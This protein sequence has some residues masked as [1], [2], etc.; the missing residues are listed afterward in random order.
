MA[1]KKGNLDKLGLLH[2]IPFS[3]KDTIGMKG[4]LNTVGCALHCFKE[5]DQ[6]AITVQRFR[7]EG[8]IPLVRGNVPQT[9][10][11]LHTTNEIWGE[12]LNPID[13]TRTAGGSSGGDSGLIAARC[14]PICLGGDIAGSL[15]WPAIF[16]GIYG[17]KPSFKRV[18]LVG[19]SPP[20][21]HRISHFTHL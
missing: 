5:C 18:S 20:R 1:R 21:L 10:F 7:E 19:L 3:V 4:F 6:D 8:G 14:V 9:C 15:R 17:F 12:S 2:G 13:T 11:S 16:C